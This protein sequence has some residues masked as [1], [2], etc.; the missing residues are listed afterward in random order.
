MVDGGRVGIEVLL[1]ALATRITFWAVGGRRY[2]PFI[3]FTASCC[4]STTGQSASKFSTLS[5]NSSRL[6]WDPCGLVL[7]S[8]T[9][10]EG[11]SPTTGIIRYARICLCKEITEWRWPAVILLRHLEEKPKRRRNCL[12]WWPTSQRFPS[13]YCQSSCSF[14]LLPLHPQCICHNHPHCI[15]LLPPFLWYNAERSWVDLPWRF[16]HQESLPLSRKLG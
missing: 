2:H 13:C 16:P 12:R 15:P 6:P 3:S 8:W 7:K 1:V 10:R 9:A 5:Q 14:I 11:C 4:A